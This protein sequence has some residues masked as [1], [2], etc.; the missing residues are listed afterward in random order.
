MHTVK[1]CHDSDASRNP[2]EA[3]ISLKKALS[4]L[5][6]SRVCG[7]TTPSENQPPVARWSLTCKTKHSGVWQDEGSYTYA[8]RG[9]LPGGDR[10]ALTDHGCREHSHRRCL[11]PQSRLPAALSQIHYV[12]PGWR[13]DFAADVASPHSNNNKP[14]LFGNNTTQ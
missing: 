4:Q 3:E 11:H 10:R 8:R 14:T 6:R 12:A 2:W 7:V 9:A 13:R 1:Q 5:F